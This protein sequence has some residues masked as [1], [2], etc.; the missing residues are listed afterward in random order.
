MANGNIGEIYYNLRIDTTTADS[1]LKKFGNSA[2]KGSTAKI[3]LIGAAVQKTFDV[4][5]NSISRSMSGAIS[6]VDTLNNFPRVMESLGYSSSEAAS[7][8][9]QIS[10]SL[11]GLPTSL[12][13]M[14]GNVQK[15]SATM[16]NLNEGVVNATSVSLAFNNMML[17]GGK[18]TAEATAAF[19][20]YNQMLAVGKVD[21]QAWNSV[22]NAAPGQVRQLAETLLGA[23]K[24]TQD[25]YEAMKEG[26]VTF[27][28]FNEAV[29]RLNTE[30]GEGFA[31]FEEQARSATG[32]IGTALENVQN[33]V[34]KA[35]G[36]VI[37]AVGQSNISSAIDSFSSQFGKLGNAVAA[38]ITGEGNPQELVQNFVD[39]ISTAFKTVL[40][41]IGT[42]IGQIVPVL[43]EAAAG[44]L[45][46]LADGL[47]KGLSSL[48]STLAKALP[49]M[50]KSVATSLADT[51][52][53]IFSSENLNI[54][55]S[56]LN[57]LLLALADAIPDV[58]EVLAGALPQILDSIIGFI[59]DPETIGSLISAFTTL[60]LS[61]IKAIPLVIQA[62]A[63][64]IPK[65]ITGITQALTNGGMIMQVLN[66]A[67]TVFYA[68]IDAIPKI[69]EAL[70]SALP[71]IITSIIN[72]LTDP[73]TITTLLN[74]A[75][76]LF[77]AIVNAVPKILGALLSSFGALVG[78]LWEGIKA[79]FGT[80]ANNFGDFIGGIFKA[81]LNGV[82][83]FI[84]G[85]INTP[86][87]LINGF[88]DVI[89]GAF[90]GIGINIGKID[91]VTLPRMYTGGIVPANSGG[92]P[93]LAGDGGEDEWVVPE[94]KMA[95]LIDK[96]EERDGGGDTFNFTFN[97]VIGTPSELRQLAVRF[98]DEYEQVRRSRLQ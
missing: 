81:A 34:N 43:V 23:G 75:I 10:N 72:F 60:W 25:L 40:P 31:S 88:I 51:L 17:A 54:I 13:D 3:A 5:A 26:D 78:G 45:P 83:A 96:L 47:L 97:G 65:I 87:N 11:D 93:I 57:D 94:S 20:Q 50:L 21:Q 98:H 4:V 95:S 61:I 15:L 14:A 6:R 7:S 8:I 63:S 30:G 77:F 33:R 2:E 9:D 85:F 27:D 29:V 19:E 67:I 28:E 24:N 37:D 82:L 42:L 59:S 52:K 46:G 32:G 18:G 55:L 90:G 39:G 70:A 35:I 91:S 68:I 49:G 16:G 71:D 79:M 92:T 44:I 62:L 73:N 64:A 80:F 56:A 12:D 84:E 1:D 69:I 74:A 38:A 53:T 36:S 76:T 86:I 48:V 66:A 89:N 58:I 41:Q 22:I